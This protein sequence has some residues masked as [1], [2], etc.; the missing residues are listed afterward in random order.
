M[1]PTPFA[2]KR[3]AVAKDQFDTKEK[4]DAKRPLESKHKVDIQN[5][6]GGQRHADGALYTHAG[7]GLT[8]AGIDHVLVMSNGGFGGIHKKLLAALGG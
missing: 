8:S 5:H 2:P 1:E 7:T 3:P 6:H 4:F